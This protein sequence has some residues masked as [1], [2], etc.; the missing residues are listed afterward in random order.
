M[1]AVM[2]V[3]GQVGQAVAKRLLQ[4]GQEVRAIVRDERKGQ[5]WSERGC[6][7]ARADANDTRSLERAFL[8]TEG[9]FAMLPPAY[10]PTP[11][12]TETRA[13]IRSLREALSEA[14]PGRAVVLSTVGGH[15]QRPNLLEQLHEMEETLRSLPLPITF[16]RPA[17]FMENASWDLPAAEKGHIESFLQ[18]VDRAIPMVSAADVGSCAG[19]LLQ[20]EW[21]GVRTEQLEGPRAYSPRDVADGFARLLKRSV[22]VSAVPREEWETLFRKQG[23]KN[24]QPRMQMLDGFNEGWLTFEAGISIRKGGTPLDTALATIA[25]RRPASG[26]S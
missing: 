15:V 13:L 4:D 3:T 18:P 22:T 26:L 6:E 11:G 20:E 8:G 9:V 25:A 10:D 21:R 7:I 14:R 12:Y 17:W 2:G 5:A 16:L 19:S 24:P 23:M 1:Y